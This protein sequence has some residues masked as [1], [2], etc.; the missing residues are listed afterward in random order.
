MTIAMFGKRAFQGALCA[1]LFALLLSCSTRNLR[2]G[3]TYESFKKPP[4]TRFLTHAT[5]GTDFEA[6]VEPV[7]FATPV[8]TERTIFLPS[9]SLGLEALDRR[10]LKRRWLISIKNGISSQ[11]ILDNGV[12]YFGANDG[13][14][15]AVDA[16][17]GKTVWK[18]ETK[19]PLYSK[20]V[21][22]SGK[23]YFTSSDDVVYCLDQNTGKWVWHYK[24]G[25]NLPTTIRG[26]SVPALDADRVYVGF[27]DGYFVSLNSKDGNIQWETRIHSGTKFTDIDAEAVIDEQR[28][29]VPSYD[30]G[31]YCIDKA[32][33]KVQWHTDVGGSK[34][35]IFDGKKLYLPS[36]DG[37]IYCLEKETGK[38]HWNFELDLGTPTNILVHGNFIA[39]GSSR[40][41][42]YVIHKGDGSLAY[43]QNIGLRSGFQGTPIEDRGELFLYSNFGNLYGFRWEKTL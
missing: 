8:V 28:I 25:V 41:Y 2:R 15:Y 3:T 24:R 11:P 32:T 16:E 7:E 26:N 40:L 1:V 22:S 35:V 18:Y 34:K 30:G 21:L 9:E 29:F 38:S 4:V 10:F 31:L 37:H 43:R 23:V 13:Y 5:R 17:L 33:G 14:F 42:F 12:L 6:G 19:A 39:F 27:S 36:S 20:A